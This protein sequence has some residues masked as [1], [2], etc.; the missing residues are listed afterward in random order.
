MDATRQEGI[1]PQASWSPAEP[2][3][4]EGGAKHFKGLEAVGGRLVLTD[5]R[6]VFASHRFNIQVH[7]EAYPL[8]QIVAVEPR[9]GISL[10]GDGMAVILADGREERFVVFGRRDWMARIQA[11]KAGAGSAV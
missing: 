7:E 9:R 4:K 1:V 8:A 3:V 2:I 5:S 6:L 11:A 10:V